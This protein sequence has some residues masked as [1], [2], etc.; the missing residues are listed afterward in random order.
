M[1]LLEEM[2]KQF[3]NL[4][5]TYE[6]EEENLEFVGIRV[7]KGGDIIEDT[8]LTEER[9]EGRERERE[10]E[11]QEELNKKWTFKKEEQKEK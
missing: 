8:D 4:D 2:S 3:P 5:F 11:E 1:L 6:Y 7:Y 9:R 10:R